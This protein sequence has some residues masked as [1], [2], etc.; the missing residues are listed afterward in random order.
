MKGSVYKRCGCRDPQSGRKIGRSCPRLDRSD[1]GAWWF[2]HDVPP[3]QDGRRRRT[4]GGPFPTRGI[5]ETELAK[6]LARLHTG[7][8][9]DTDRELTV[10]RYL[11]DWMEGKVKLRASTR[12]SYESHIRL[13]LKPGLGH[14]R[15]ADLRDHH[16]EQL[17]AAM[18]QIGHASKEGKPSPLL[19]RLVEVR[20]DSPDRRRPMSPAR[21]RRV[22]AT[23]MSALN[24]AVKRRKISH[25]PAQYVELASGRAPKP[26][27][28]TAGRVAAWQNSGR[29][30]SPVM[31]WT[32]AQAGAFLDF[33]AADRLYPL[34]HLVAYRGPRRGEAVALGW[35]D[36]DLDAGSAYIR[37]NL[38]DP[39]DFGEDEWGDPKSDAGFRPISL[40]SRT[41]TVLVTW[42]ATQNAERLLHGPDWVDCGRV[43]THENGRRLTP[44]G[45]SQRFDRLLARFTTIRREH[46]DKGWDTAFLA[47]RHRMPVVAIETA[48]AFGPL[49]PIR[50]HDL[51]HTAASLTY[52]ATRDL[53]LVSEL[54]GHS[55]IQFTSDVYTSIFEEVDRDAAEAVADIVPRAHRPAGSAPEGTVATDSPMG[56]VVNFDRGK[57]VTG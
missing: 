17:Y 43:F 23:V 4:M 3:G 45:V 47:A 57:D 19:R 46:E 36:V 28:W 33:A 30:P 40:D 21:I 48:L 32:P 10:A 5:A 37:D 35:A 13:Y 38:P 12:R 20:Q 27:V 39:D 41:V 24:S 49:P 15:L 54:L 9:T 44:N 29:R 26:L 18:R 56:T 31:V 14:L 34:W 42:R 6:A 51:R 50:L 11:D 22:H 1:H 52:R 2:L 8:H 7:G 55:S 16:V 25:N 53:K